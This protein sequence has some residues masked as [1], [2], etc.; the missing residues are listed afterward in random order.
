M[1]NIALFGTYPPPYGGRSVHLKRLY[2][3]LTDNGN[4]VTIYTNRRSSD[5]QT[6]WKYNFLFRM[7]KD[8]YDIVH[9]HDQSLFTILWVAFFSKILGY[10][11]ILT[12]HSFR[13]S[14]QDYSLMKK[15]LFQISFRRIDHFIC[16]GTNEN[17]KLQTLLNI[18]SSIIPSYIPPSY[19]EEDIKKI[20][21]DV[22]D[23]VYS[24][25]FL[26]TANGNIKFYNNED[27]Y[28]FDMLIHLINH[29]VNNKGLQ[30]KLLIAVLGI[31]SQ[32]Y[33]ERTYY[34]TLKDLIWRFN[35]YKSIYLFE[36]KNTELYPL[37]QKSN[38]FIRPT[39]TDS[40]GI[41]VAESISFNVP[42][43]A[44]DVC[45]RPNGTVLFQSRN[46][47][48]MIDQVLDTIQNYMICKDNVSKVVQKN[49]AKEILSLYKKL[50]D[51][52][53]SKGGRFM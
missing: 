22:W 16:V 33:Q 17:N 37:I 27:L 23:F 41:S 1:S 29:L 2:H 32:S 36:V 51:K 42:A 15:L 48:N 12:L 5:S 11:L 39:N 10:T 35:L 44:S 50:I 14:P 49:H 38:L 31:D 28:G 9:F 45:V 4:V 21:Q 26:I 24:A 13:E 46:L 18:Q 40:Y 6:L 53:K 43:I 30:V 20:P 7:W 8:R 47:H 34:N 25:E 19:M 3:Y 52:K